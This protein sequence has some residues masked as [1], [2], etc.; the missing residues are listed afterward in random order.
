M[1][2]FE[3]CP[4][5]ANVVGIAVLWQSLDHRLVQ[6]FSDRKKPQFFSQMGSMQFT[7]SHHGFWVRRCTDW[8][9]FDP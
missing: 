3:A 5:L 2:T 9:W 4:C 7:I 1:E 8:K 6:S